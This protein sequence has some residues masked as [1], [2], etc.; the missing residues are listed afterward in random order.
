[1]GTILIYEES[2]QAQHREKITRGYF[3]ES[4]T[5][6]RTCNLATVNVSDYVNKIVG[7]INYDNAILELHTKGFMGSTL[8]H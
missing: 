6:L 7:L 5:Y 2:L 4:I 1:M 3:L 8:K